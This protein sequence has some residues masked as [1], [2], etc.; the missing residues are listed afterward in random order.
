MSE[1]FGLDVSHYQG[2][3]NWQSVAAQGRK[4]VIMKCQYE[5]L[6]HRVDETFEYNYKQAGVNGLARGVYIFIG[7]QSIADPVADAL[8]LLGHLKGRYLEYGIWLDYESAKLRA[9]GKERIKDLTKI[10]DDI[11]RSAGYYVGIYCNLDWYKN[12]IHEE[13]KSQYAF[14]LARYPKKDLGSYNASSSLKPS[15]KYAVAWQYSSKGHIQGIIGNVDL[16]VDYDGIVNL[17][18]SG[19]SNEEVAKEVIEGKWGTKNT[20]PS[21]RDLLTKAGYDY[22][23]IQKIVNKMLMG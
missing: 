11:F 10:Y 7:S 15:S 16:D 12:V 23:Q 2:A 3:I 13:L 14:W 8:S 6:P 22:D 19:K 4:F 20:R 5:A 1:V 18:A 9:L 17:L 21:R